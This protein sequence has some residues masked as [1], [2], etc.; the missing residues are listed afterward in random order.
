[1]AI[2]EELKQTFATER[3]DNSKANPTY[4]GEEIF[5]DKNDAHV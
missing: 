1:M 5:V 4:R 2:V 3:T